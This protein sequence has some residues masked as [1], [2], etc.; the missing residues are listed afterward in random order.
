MTC[1]PCQLPEQMIVVKQLTKDPKKV[2][3][4][5]EN[6]FGIPFKDLASCKRHRPLVEARMIVADY[7][8]KGCGL[9]SKAIGRIFNRDYSSVLHNKKTLSNLLKVDKNINEKTKGF[10][11]RLEDNFSDGR[12]KAGTNVTKVL[13]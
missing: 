7:L 12:V 8:F 13:N 6:Y 4:V 10:L 11:L 2:I 1:Y 5:A 9:S 3:A